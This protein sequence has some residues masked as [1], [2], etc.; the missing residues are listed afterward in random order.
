MSEST[1]KSIDMLFKKYILQ[2]LG[3]LPIE[4]YQK[5]NELQLFSVYN[6]PPENWNVTLFNILNFSE[7]LNIAIWSSW[8]NHQRYEDKSVEEFAD[9][10][11]QDYFADD[12]RIDIWEEG[13]LEAAQRLIQEYR[14]LTETERSAS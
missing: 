9:G 8:I 4:D 12:S 14:L 7:T 6:R 1:P 11:V 5:L 13:Q 3:E 10:F 2:E